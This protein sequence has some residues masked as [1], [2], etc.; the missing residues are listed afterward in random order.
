MQV[1]KRT[2]ELRQK[3]IDDLEVE[4]NDLEKRVDAL[5]T[6]IAESSK[7]SNDSSTQDKLAATHGS[8]SA[9]L[10]KYLRGILDNGEEVIV[11]SYWHDTLNLVWRS[12]KKAN[13]GSSSFCTGNSSMMA[14][15]IDDFTIG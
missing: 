12:L 7:L 11:F 9:A 15:A 14:K 4:K 10:I 3:A 8:K 1:T 2:I 6:N 5:S 13:L